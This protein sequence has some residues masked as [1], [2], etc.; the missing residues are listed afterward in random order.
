MNDVIALDH[1]HPFLRFVCHGFF[2]LVFLLTAQFKVQY[3]M[4]K[5]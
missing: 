3:G 1:A 4:A 5:D 2:F